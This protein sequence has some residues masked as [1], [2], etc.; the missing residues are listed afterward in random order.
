MGSEGSAPA[1]GFIISR[2]ARHKGCCALLTGGRGGLCLAESDMHGAVCAQAGVR[3]LAD[4]PR[5]DRVRPGVLRAEHAGGEGRLPQGVLTLPLPVAVGL[6]CTK[7]AS[8]QRA[9]ASQH[10]MHNENR[11][12]MQAPV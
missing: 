1:R 8:T 3:R 2:R 9:G 10:V 12:R 7:P 11:S 4:P 5:G 6:I